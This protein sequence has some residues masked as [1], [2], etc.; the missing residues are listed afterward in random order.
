MLHGLDEGLTQ[1]LNYGVLHLFMDHVKLTTGMPKT[2]VGT[3]QSPSTSP[4]SP[5]GAFMAHYS[6]PTPL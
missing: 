1:K 2:T 4:M 6:M 5:Y 3:D